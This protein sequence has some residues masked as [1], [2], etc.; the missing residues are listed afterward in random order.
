MA[1][2]VVINVNHI[3]DHSL[4]GLQTSRDNLLQYN[5]HLNNQ[6]APDALLF[7][8]PLLIVLSTFL[9]ILLI[10]LV[11]VIFVRRRRGIV[12]RDSDGPTDMSR[13]ELMNG[14]GGLEGVE[15]RWLESVSEHVRRSYLRAKDY[16]LQYAP[17]SEPTDITLSQFLS[18]QEKGVSAWSFEPD[19]ETI[20]SLLVHARTEITFL[21]DPASASC[22]QSNLPLPKLN[23]VYYWEVKMF[24]L[25]ETTT[26]AVGLATKPY[27]PFRLPGLNLFSVAY[28]SSGDKCYNY[29][30][31]ASPFGP[32]LKEGDILGIGYRPRTGTVFFTRNGR[33]MEDA[34]IGLNRYNLFPTIGADGPCSVHVNLGQAGFVFIEANVKKWGLAPTVGTLAPPPAY[35]SERGSIL[36]DV[37]GGVR[38]GAPIISTPSTSSTPRRRS[39]R[40]RRPSNPLSASS[41]LTPPPPIT[42]IIEEPDSTDP[43][44]GQG[45]LSPTDLPF[46]TPPNHALPLYPTTE[47]ESEQ[48]DG[49]GT[50]SHSPTSSRSQSP[51]SEG[52][53]GASSL[54]SI[55]RFRRDSFTHFLAAMQHAGSDLAIQVH[56]PPDSPRS[57]NP[58]TP[59]PRDIHLEA[60]TSSS[61]EGSDD[62]SEA[63]SPTFMRRD[64]PAYSP[65][66]AF[67]YAEGVHI[68]L[69][70][71]VI[72]AALEGD[73]IPPSAIGQ[74]NSD[75]SERR[76]SRRA[77]R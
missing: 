34:F 55:P 77:R 51:E 63:R 28:H 58:P 49:D 26:V 43:S 13:E 39:H 38:P 67:T 21:P 53:A 71:D 25:P 70:A 5:S 47:G 4:T 7:I 59:Q 6:P 42:P 66:D 64:P 72:A 40:S 36:L 31:T 45:Y 48:E 29:P 16:Q 15:S 24:D 54:F 73:S 65:L 14:E 62:A 60:F 8:L 37:G 61:A 9:F 44:I 41:V 57:P 19:Y 12:L 17:N 74:G 46:H 2:Q 32:L 23:E 22:V 52:A 18:I 56:P 11:C 3:V 27:P 30:F 1:T 75:R 33:K 20:N 69:P 76:R 50:P 35:G 10:F 68:D